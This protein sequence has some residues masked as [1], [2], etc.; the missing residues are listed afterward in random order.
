MVSKK[1]KKFSDCFSLTFRSIERVLA[2]FLLRTAD[3]LL[4]F[5]FF[6]GLSKGKSQALHDDMHQILFGLVG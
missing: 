1:R 5:F 4:R 2:G 6:G 3:N